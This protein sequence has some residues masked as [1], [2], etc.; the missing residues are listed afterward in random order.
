M[1]CNVGLYAKLKKCNFHQF[2]VKFFGYIVSCDDISMDHKIFKQF[3]NGQHQKR[4]VM[5]SVSL[6]LRIF[7]E[8]S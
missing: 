7:I 2:Q 1:L 6:D 8:S 4:Y 3:W 5:S